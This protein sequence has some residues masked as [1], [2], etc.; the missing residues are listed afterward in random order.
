MP[1]ESLVSFFFYQKIIHINA[2]K[3][4][5]KIPGFYGGLNTGSFQSRDFMISGNSIDI[6]KGGLISESFSL[7]I[8]SQKK[9]VKL[10]ST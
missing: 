10:L 4:D 5:A 9:C 2:Y 3:G 6:T 7:R 8:K 1:L